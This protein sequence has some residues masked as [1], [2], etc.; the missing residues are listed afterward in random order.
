MGLRCSPGF[1]RA[2]PALWS[3]RRSGTPA[4]G[5]SGEGVEDRPLPPPSWVDVSRSRLHFHG[6]SRPL[7]QP[8]PTTVGFDRT[9]GEEKDTAWLSV[10]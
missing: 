7:P 4:A 10:D 5:L 3:P 2:G 9:S 1:C 6:N 8:S